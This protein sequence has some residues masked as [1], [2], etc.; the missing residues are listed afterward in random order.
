MARLLSVLVCLA[1]VMPLASAY[2]SFFLRVRRGGGGGGVL[3]LQ[4]GVYAAVEH[5]KSIQYE[6]LDS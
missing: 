5:I 6:C 3:P 4:D 2:P 1:F